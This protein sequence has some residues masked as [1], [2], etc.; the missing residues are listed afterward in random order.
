MI[1]LFTWNNRY[2][3]QQE[4]QKWKQ[5]FWD[6]YGEENISHIA[7]LENTSKEI[8]SESLVSRS[9]LSEKRLVIIDGFPYSWEKNFSW[10]ADIEKLIL[11]QS[12]N[13]PEE[14]LVVFLSENPDKRKS[15]FK[16]LA[17]IAEVKEF[18]VSWEDAVYALLSQKY[19]NRIASQA[20]QRLIFL[21]GWNLEKSLWEIEKLLISNEKI[22]LQHIEEN[23]IPEFEES[24]FV[25]IDTLLQKKATKV[26][27][28]FWNLLEYSN[29]YAVYQ[30][31]IANLRVF[32]YI[33]HLKHNKKSPSEITDIL[34]L[35]NRSFLINKRH[36]T[37]HADIQTLYQNLLTFDKKMKFGK[38]ISS[39]EEDL[40]KELER[41]FLR[42]LA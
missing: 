5:A 29:M 7:S 33:E 12:S 36:N 23:I 20:L 9:L 19:W 24:I 17:K 1:Y 10:A 40:Q 13:I 34:K 25:F 30:S 41:I 37:S 35:G 8:I 6:K 11:E 2:L 22:E 28:E 42:F 27:D 14:V 26:L 32:L 16:S 21:K 15:W 18:S 3:I 4:A 31:I 39:D 38:Y